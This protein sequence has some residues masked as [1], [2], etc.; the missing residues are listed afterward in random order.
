MSPIRRTM[1]DKANTTTQST[2]YKVKGF[3]NVCQKN[4]R[5]RQ[6]FRVSLPDGDC[7]FNQ[8]IALDLMNITG[9][10]ILHC[11]DKDTKFNASAFLN[12]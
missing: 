10:S 2:I 5:E 7:V 8:T 1:T 4:A 12:L 3:F 6:R 11:E 9:R